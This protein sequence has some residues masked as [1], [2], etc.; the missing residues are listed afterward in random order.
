MATADADRKYS[1]RSYARPGIQLLGR[2]DDSL[3]TR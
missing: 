3:T 2:P 1:V